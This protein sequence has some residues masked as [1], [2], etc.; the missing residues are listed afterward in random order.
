MPMMILKKQ[1]KTYEKSNQIE[2]A[3]PENVLEGLNLKDETW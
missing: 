1:I 2:V 3:I